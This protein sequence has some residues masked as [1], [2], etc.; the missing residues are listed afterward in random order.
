MAHIMLTR[1]PLRQPRSGGA[2]AVNRDIGGRPQ[3]DYLRNYCFARRVA[4]DQS[5][6][7][8]RFLAAGCRGFEPESA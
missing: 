8:N 4:T 2:E 6:N 3:A 5:T 7:T 1:T